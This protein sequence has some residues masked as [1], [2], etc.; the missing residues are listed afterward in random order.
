MVDRSDKPRPAGKADASPPGGLLSLV[1]WTAV[2]FLATLSLTVFAARISQKTSLLTVPA[3][4][5]P[6]L[7]VVVAAWLILGYPVWPGALLG[8]ADPRGGFWR[9]LLLRL[10]EVGIVLGVALPF[11]LAAAVFSGQPLTRAAEVPLGLAGTALAAVAYRL[12]HQALGDRLRALALIDAGTFLFAPL[13]VGYVLLDFYHVSIGWC[14][15][16]SPLALGRELSL[17]GLPVGGTA[18]LIGTVGYVA[19]AALGLWLLHWLVRRHPPE[20]ASGASRQADD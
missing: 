7:A 10:A 5:L 13:V 14:W 20:A 15:L 8:Q 3:Q 18:F 12:V 16:I 1:A 2:V 19:V 11:L 6:V 4:A 9:W 17:G